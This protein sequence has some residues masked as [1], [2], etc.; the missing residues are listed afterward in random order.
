MILVEKPLV[1]IRGKLNAMELALEEQIKTTE[2][3]VIQ[4][5]IVM[6][7]ELAVC[8]HGHHQLVQYAQLKL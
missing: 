5:D 4:P 8:H 3:F 1:L 7:L 2:Q 6:E